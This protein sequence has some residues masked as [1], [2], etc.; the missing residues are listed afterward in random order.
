MVVSNEPHLNGGDRDE[1]PEPKDLKHFTK[2][3][4]LLHPLLGMFGRGSKQMP[5]YTSS[6]LLG[7][8]GSCEDELSE[9]YKLSDYHPMFPHGPAECDVATYP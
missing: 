3:Y 2:F 5:R 8:V 9:F 1:C 7:I 6:Y 4:R